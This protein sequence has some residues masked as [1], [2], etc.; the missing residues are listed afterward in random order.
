MR[1]VDEYR[2]YAMEAQEHA[3][4]SFCEKDKAGWQRIAQS[5][6]SILRDYQSTPEAQFEKVAESRGT[7]QACSTSMH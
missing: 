7:G 5:W 1:K 6:L 4:R 3:N 2:R